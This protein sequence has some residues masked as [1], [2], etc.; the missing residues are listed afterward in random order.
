M[1]TTKK[2]TAA[3][4]KT[5]TTAT[6]KPVASKTKVTAEMVPDLPANPFI[7]EILNAVVKMSTDEKKVEVL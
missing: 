4:T 7:F 2:T 3:A 6:R 5:K 1:T